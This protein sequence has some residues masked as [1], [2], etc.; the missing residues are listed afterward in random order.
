MLRRRNS[1]KRVFSVRVPEFDCKRRGNNFQY[2]MKV[3][4]LVGSC[5]NDMQEVVRNISE[6]T[7]E[8]ILYKILMFDGCKT[9]IEIN[10]INGTVSNEHHKILFEKQ[11]DTIL[12]KKIQLRAEAGLPIFTEID[13]L[14][15]GYKLKVKMVKNQA[16]VLCQKLQ[17]I[18]SSR[19]LVNRLQLE[20]MVGLIAVDTSTQ[21]FNL[22][23]NLEVELNFEV[24]LGVTV[25]AKYTSVDGKV[26]LSD[27]CDVYIPVYTGEQ[28]LYRKYGW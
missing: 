21:E 23:I 13:R 18:T 16:K 25:V 19:E 6:V 26:T 27:C 1:K 4:A 28:L 7:P 20:P 11:R 3:V 15:N 8:E 14:P 24:N 2:Q 5:Y 22:H 10:F 17:L 12:D 9:E